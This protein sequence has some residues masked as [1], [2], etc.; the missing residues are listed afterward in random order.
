MVGVSWHPWLHHIRKAFVVNRQGSRRRR[1]RLS[2]EILED[3]STPSSITLPTSADN[4]LYQV[5]TSDPMQQLSNG[6]GGFFFV[7]DTKQLSNNI[8]RGTIKFDLSGVPA[9][10]TITSATLMLQMSQAVSTVSQNVALHRALSDWGE[11]GSVSPGGG[12]AGAPAQT[13]DTTWFYTFFDTQ[14]WTT[15]GGDFVGTASAT[16]PVGPDIGSYQWSDSGLIA[17]VQQWVNNPAQNFGWIVTGNETGLGTALQFDT[18]EN[19]VAS[20]HPMLTVTYTAASQLA[21]VAP[22]TATAGMPFDLT[23]T[24]QDSSGNTASGFNGSVT[25]SSSGGADLSPASVTL[26][27]GTAT[28]PVTLT[29]AGTQT[30]MAAF[31]GL[32]PGMASVAVSPGPFSQYLVAVQGSSRTT[33]GMPVLATV[34]AADQFGNPVFN[35]TGP[36]SVTASISPVSTASNFPMTVTVNST[37]LGLLLANL[38]QAGT[39]TITAASGSFTGS[40]SPLTVVPGPAAN[41]AFAAQPVN[42]PTGVTLAPVTV[43]VLDAYANVVTADNS[44]VVTL[45]VASGPGT[46]TSGSTV[47]AAVHS[48]VATFNNLTLVKPG[49][50]A[51]SELVTGLYTGP[52]SNSF[53]VAP[54]Q[55]VPGSFV[56][57]P[58]GFSLQFNAPILINAL[59]PVLYGQGFGPTAP[60]PSVTVT[61][62]SGR[63]VGT[64]IVNTAT[65][66][67]TFVQ[68]DTTSFVNSQAGTGPVSPL[69]P[70]GVYTVD[71]SS[72]AARNGFQALGSGGGFLDGKGSGNPGSGDFT[73]T[74]TVGAA[75]A[76]DDVVW[77]PA[78]ADGPLQSLQ[79]PGNN[80][81]N[82]PGLLTNGYPIYLDDS[83]G[84]VTSVQLTLNYNPAMLTV[85]GATSNSAVP[86]SSFTLLAASTPGHAVLQYAGTGAGASHLTGNGVP[87]GFITATVPNSSAATPIYRG[88]DLL[89]LS[90]LVINEGSIPVAGGDAVHVVAFAGDADGNGAYSSGDAV[91]I[92]RV[93]VSTDTGFAA[94]PLIDPTIVADTDGSGFI[95]SDA[96]LQAN[97]AGV[98]FQTANLA[99]PPIPSGANVTPIGNGGDH[100]ISVFHLA[101]MAT[102]PRMNTDVRG[103]WGGQPIRLINP[104]EALD[105]Y[106][107]QPDSAAVIPE[108]FLR[109]RVH[110]QSYR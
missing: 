91:L 28:V 97:E 8:R 60:A 48:G 69:L 59:T 25:L 109:P 40:A 21:L 4:T 55:V 99:N 19:S 9:G 58:S 108:G 42:T 53:T 82:Q 104:V 96:A 13:G 74:F 79:A 30:I 31:S 33:A 15:P 27:N 36:S 46:F 5:A 84:N 63:V 44:D 83:T 95:P 94:Y 64:L 107:A 105:W 92:T 37:G 35:Y 51:L 103:K 23:V 93:L 14:T 87:L 98:G 11:G 3:R 54:L 62:P 43:Q 76:G 41:L 49:S 66:T 65:N 70:D 67:I 47:S 16:T 50:Y 20:T 52:S 72:T 100:L 24:A 39:Y 12:G 22:P 68:T 34:Q 78:T 89:H 56:G 2:L 61:G 7:G 110:R 101:A 57:T 77:V 86:G 81:Q 29:G 38:Q 10:S 1:A 80:Q 75:A 45:G 106:F 90:G 18:K 88:K 73:A 17:D 26:T 102:E 71:L 6:A 85:T 32:T